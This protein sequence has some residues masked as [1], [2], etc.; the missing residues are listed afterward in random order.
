MPYFIYKIKQTPI[1]QLQKIEQHD[2]YRDASARAKVLRA[3]LKDEQRMVKIVF[4]EH[5]LG[6]EDLLSQVREPVPQP[7]DD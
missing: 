1:L 3:E 4:A 7:G 5:E 2:A 6:A